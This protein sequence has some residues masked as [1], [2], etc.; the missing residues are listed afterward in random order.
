MCLTGTK[1]STPVAWAEVIFRNFSLHHS[2]G[3]CNH[4]SSEE[5]VLVTKAVV[6]V[7]ATT[8]VTNTAATVYGPM[9]DSTYNEMR[10][11]AL[12]EHIAKEI[13]STRN[14]N[15]TKVEKITAKWNLKFP[16][17]TRGAAV[18]QWHKIS[19]ACSQ[20]LAA[21]TMIETLSPSGT[22]LEDLYEAA[23]KIYCE[24]EAPSRKKK[25]QE[26][27]EFEYSECFDVLRSS[28]PGDHGKWANPEVVKNFLKLSRE[29]IAADKRDGWEKVADL[30]DEDPG[31]LLRS[32]PAVANG[33][34]RKKKRSSSDQDQS[35]LAVQ[36]VG[37]KRVKNAAAMQ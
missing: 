31:V 29:K 16:E 32:E 7:S 20:Y 6:N 14:C 23:T 2:M 25:H 36:L 28:F 37:K 3:R 5:S 9:V 10:E 33:G 8:D 24:L 18:M 11:K 19:K 15:E 13:E 4:W 34:K 30:P 17:R 1:F 26:D 12:E 21:F 27:Y 22:T 35:D